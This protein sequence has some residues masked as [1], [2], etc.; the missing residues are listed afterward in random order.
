MLLPAAV[1]D[2]MLP[3]NSK[4]LTELNFLILSFKM[5]TYCRRSSF[6]FNLTSVFND[7]FNRSDLLYEAVYALNS[8]LDHNL[9]KMSNAVDA[10]S[11]F[12]MSEDVNPAFRKLET[13]VG[14]N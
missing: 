10:L 4:S 9:Y 13:F 12:A 1:I 7:L 3:Q 14:V 11:S 6:V 2:L 8:V 5:S